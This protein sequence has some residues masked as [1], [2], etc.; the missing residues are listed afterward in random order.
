MR[1]QDDHREAADNHHE[2]SRGQLL[3]R[4]VA[5]VLSFTVLVVTGYGWLNYRHLLSGVATSEIRLGSSSDGSM[6]ILLVGV[7]SRT[8]AQGNPLP[9]EVSAELHTGESDAALTDTIILL[10]LANNGSEAIGISFPR[11]SH[12]TIPGHG[13]HKLNSAYSRGKQQAAEQLAAQGASDP[14]VLEERSA[15]AGRELLVRTVERL[16]QVQID[17]Y[18]EINMLGFAQLTEEVGGVPVCLNSPVQ[19]PYSGADFRAGPQRISGADALA[20]VRQRHGLPRGDLD[21]MIRQQAFLAGFAQAVTSSGVLT[22]PAKLRE[23]TSSVRRS[24]VLDEDWDLLSFA[25]RMREM[26]TSVRFSTAPIAG[27]ARTDEDG[28]VVLIDETALR[29]TV[30]H[31]AGTAGEG[32][33]QQ[34]APVTDEPLERPAPPSPGRSPSHPA[35]PPEISTEGV[36]CVN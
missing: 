20:F 27:T 2:A 11:D 25:G 8:D 1:Q 4:S 30:R 5:V 19:D 33:A 24:V 7:D 23:L 13:Q 32:P 21:R 26:S 14:D 18:A 16:A 34:V 35:P 22:N 28:D 31:Y 15:E 12:V 6:D 3:A 29:S 36:P 10:H 9:D 17:H